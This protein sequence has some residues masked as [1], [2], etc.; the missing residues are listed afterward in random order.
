M[1]IHPLLNFEG[2]LDTSGLQ[3]AQ[4]HLGLLVTQMVL[5]RFGV[6]SF[7]KPGDG[8]RVAD[9]VNGAH[10]VRLAYAR[11]LESSVNDLPDPRRAYRKQPFVRRYAHAVRV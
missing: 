4:G 11:S 10:V 6:T 3:V 9:D 5:E 7:I 8:S 2:F 1:E